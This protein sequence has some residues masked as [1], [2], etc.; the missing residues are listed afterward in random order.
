[1]YPLGKQPPKR[2]ARL[3]KFA[4]YFNIRKLPTPPAAFGKYK[5]L[6]FPMLANDRYGDCVFAGAAHETRVWCR[7]RNRPIYFTNKGVLSDYSAVTGFDPK[8]PMTDQGTNMTDAASYRR[9]TGI[10]DAAGV[11]HQIDSYVSIRL[12]NVE[13]LK[14]AMWLAG[15]AGVGVQFPNTAWRQFQRRE[16]WDRELNAQLEGGH[17]MAAVGWSPAGNIVCVTWGRRIEM[18]PQFW[19]EY[20]DECF[21]YLSLTRLEQKL[22]PEGFDAD[23]LREDLAS[24]SR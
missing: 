21:V 10:V 17:Y 1:M 15:G 6:R 20:C 9:K 18:T 2:D 4:T 19:L 16:V 14:T 13:Q 7:E 24:L 22:S 23:T 3:F 8:N 5:G 12:G 11:R